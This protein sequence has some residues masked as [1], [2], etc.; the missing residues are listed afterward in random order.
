MQERT[1]GSQEPAV[2]AMP[3]ALAGQRGSRGAIL[4]RVE[5][6]LARPHAKIAL[7]WLVAA[8]L[9]LAPPRSA[10]A[11]VLDLG[12]V[13]GILD[14]SVGYGLMVRT[15]ERD[16]DFVGIANGGN[17]PTVNIDDGNLNYDKRIFANEIRLSA[18]LTL[19]WR[20]FGVFIRGFGF[21]DFETKLHDRERTELSG[22]AEDLVGSGGELQEY[23]LS[24]HFTPGGMPI[25]VRVGQQVLNWGVGTFLRFGTDIVNP[26]DFVSLLRPT[27]S[28]RDLYEPLGMLWIASNVTELIALEAFYQYEWEPVVES[29]VGYFFSADD[30]IG[31]GGTN[32]YVTG[33][34]RFSD[35]GTNLDDAFGLAPGTLGFDP[36]F[37]RVPSAGTDDARQ[38]GQY[39]FAMSLLL[40]ML[41]TSTVRLYFVNYHAR[42]PIINAISADQTAIDAAVA[43][44]AGNPTPAEQTIALGTLSNETRYFASYREDI[45]MLGFSF[46][47]VLPYTGTLG[48]IDLSHHFNWPAQQ[49]KDVVIATAL[50]PL[51][52]AIAGNSPGP[53]AANQLVSGVDQTHKTQLAVQIAQALGP[54]FGASRSFLIANFG[55]AHFDGL[56]PSPVFTD[57]SWGYSLTGLMS[58]DGVFGGV[59]LQPFVSFTHDVSG[60]TPGP[61]GAFTEDRKSAS[62][63]LNVDWTNRI[64][65]N[66]TYVNF[67]S[68][69]PLN[70]GVDRDFITFN[71]RF[72][73]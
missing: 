49:L 48:G 35:Q 19:A 56:S 42:L 28:P 60:T 27:A 25:Q 66:L 21:Y 1:A 33:G 24:G 46:D 10:D 44:G 57:D 17:A 2:L 26:I 50:S 15:Q 73:Y 3:L 14:L 18:D 22:R 13:A 67:F 62:V 29:P 53:I 11:K 39:G 65:A 47:G 43:I 58:Y 70:A 71:V 7:P 38:Q 68:G 72:Y 8:I 5:T 45:R 54:Q 16:L 9:L 52:N 36:N 69:K 55:W 64:T 34:G 41:N 59:N 37:M 6:P 30:L 32:K 12:P 40:P 61:V 23:Y 31:G 4:H 20:N 63:G 51:A